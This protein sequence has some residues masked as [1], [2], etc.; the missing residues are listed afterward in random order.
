MVN[1]DYIRRY[2][3]PVAPSRYRTKKPA[4]AP[5]DWVRLVLPNRRTIWLQMGSSFNAA[6]ELCMNLDDIE[7][8]DPAWRL[9]LA[10][11]SP[12]ILAGMAL[13]FNHSAFLHR[14]WR[15]PI[16]RHEKQRGETDESFALRS[17]EGYGVIST[18]LRDDAK[19]L[20]L[21]QAAQAEKRIS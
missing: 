14:R 1:Q 7:D 21:V 5:G 20:R 10:A 3:G 4:A 16:W 2:R 19:L 12:T 8:D 13:L 18:Y 6:H 11:L 9:A 17:E 15:M